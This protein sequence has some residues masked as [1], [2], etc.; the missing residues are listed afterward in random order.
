MRPG[1][2]RRLRRAAGQPRGASRA[3]CRVRVPPHRCR[4]APATGRRRICCASYPRLAAFGPRTRGLLQPPGPCGRVSF[5]GYVA[6]PLS[7]AARGRVPLVLHEQNSRPGL[8]NR[9]AARFADHVAVTFPSSVRA[10]P[11][12][13]RCGS[14]GTRSS[15]DCATSTS[16]ARRYEARRRLGLDPSRTDAARVRWEPGCSEHQPC[17]RR[18]RSGLA[19]RS[20]CRSCTSRDRGP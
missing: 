19:A 2:H 5:G 17:R 9:L 10:P 8:A 4:A 12:T 16:S 18:C 3:G 15:S 13:D 20:V 7:L 1:L 14:R 6:L 11:G